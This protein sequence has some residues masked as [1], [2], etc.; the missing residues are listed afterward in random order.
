MSGDQGRRAPPV[1]GTKDD[2][3]RKTLDLSNLLKPQY[4]SPA[5]TLRKKDFNGD[6]PSSPSTSN[7]TVVAKMPPQKQGTRPSSIIKVSDEDHRMSGYM[8]S[9][10]L[11]CSHVKVCITGREKRRLSR[12]ESSKRGQSTYFYLIEVQS[13]LGT[14]TVGKRYSDFEQMHT[15]LVRVLPQ[16]KVE[17]ELLPRLPPK[18]ALQTALQ[19]SGLSDTLEQVAEERQYHLNHYLMQ[20]VRIPI[21]WSCP[22]LVEFLDDTRR[23][24]SLLWNFERM[25]QMQT[26]LA[27]LA[28]DNKVSCPH[29]THLLLPC[30]VLCCLSFLAPDLPL[31]HP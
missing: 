10:V 24:L 7:A 3:P 22:V 20:L 31:R 25:M 11:E 1:A 18:K 2:P 14:W 26:A 12:K 15:T 21:V 4:F 16:S 5:N 28:V 27:H 8:S 19:S 13:G 17:P 23:S 30:P 6:V 29:N 9:A